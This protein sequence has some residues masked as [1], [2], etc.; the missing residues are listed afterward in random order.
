MSTLLRRTPGQLARLSRSTST[1]TP[2]T[3][4]TLRR[5][6]PVPQC[7]YAQ[8]RARRYAT[9]PQEPENKDEKKDQSAAKKDNQPEPGEEGKEGKAEEKPSNANMVKTDFFEA[10]STNSQTAFHQ[11]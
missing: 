6:V 4:F 2:R 9:G 11:K 1:V 8:Q 10:K 7:L 3:P 5:R